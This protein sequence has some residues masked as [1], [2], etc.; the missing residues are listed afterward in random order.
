MGGSGAVELDQEDGQ[1]ALTLG[2]FPEATA[3]TFAVD[4][5]QMT[6]QCADEAEEAAFLRASGVELG[7]DVYV[8]LVD[9]SVARDPERVVAAIQRSS[10]RAAIVGL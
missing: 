2:C 10:P 8:L 3:S 7:A 1:L 5:I 9:Q 4:D 6:Q